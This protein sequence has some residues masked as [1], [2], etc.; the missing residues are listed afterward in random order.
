MAEKGKNGGRDYKKEYAQ[1]HS[2]PEQIANR[3]KRNEARAEYEKKHGDLPSN[4]DV[5][6]KKRLAKGGSNDPKNLRA[7]SESKNSGWRKGKKGYD[8]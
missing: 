3:A 2:K 7:V 1:Y 5:D 8:R 6:H 4:V